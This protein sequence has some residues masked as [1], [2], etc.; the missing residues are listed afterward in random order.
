M[1]TRRRR[2]AEATSSTATLHC[3]R[4]DNYPSIFPTVKL[5]KPALY[6]VNQTL[7][8]TSIPCPK[9]VPSVCHT[10]YASHTCMSSTRSQNTRD[11]RLSGAGCGVG[12]KT[13]GMVRPPSPTVSEHRVRAPSPSAH[14]TPAASTRLRLLRALYETARPPL[15]PKIRVGARPVD[16]TKTLLR[17]ISVS[18]VPVP[19]SPPGRGRGGGRGRE[20]DG[21]ATATAAAS[22]PPPQHQ[23][24]SRGR[25]GG[26]RTPSRGSQRER[27]RERERRQGAASAA[28]RC[29]R[30]PAASFSESGPEGCALLPGG[31][32]EDRAGAFGDSEFL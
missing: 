16:Q 8:S 27:R 23:G 6:V 3:I 18:F 19:Q 5:A 10:K 13:S 20:R 11:R 29:Q 30:P 21:S 1:E 2:E 17:R 22:R 24:E 4:H 32:C 12:R 9:E 25:R 14:I 31:G 28:A 15:V 7:S 26:P